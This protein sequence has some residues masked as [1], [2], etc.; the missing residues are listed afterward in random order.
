M[1]NTIYTD[2]RGRRYPDLKGLVSKD[3]VHM[4]IEY[5][6]SYD[7]SSIVKLINERSLRKLQMEFPELKKD[8]WVVIFRLLVLDVGV[9]KIL[10]MK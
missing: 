7:I 1:K 2:L 10:Q 3:H 5:R 6:P 8:I 9:Q 4:H